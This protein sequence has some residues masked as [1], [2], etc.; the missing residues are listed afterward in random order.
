M[1]PAYGDSEA[2]D[3]GETSD[4]DLSSIQGGVITIGNF[5][6]VH[7]G[8]AALLGHV[9]KLA[10]QLGGPAI[11]MVLDPHPATILRPDVAPKRLTQ[12]ET[13]AELMDQLGIDALVVCKTSRRF[14]DLSAEQFFSSLVQ[15]RLQ[16][17]AMIEGPNFFLVE[18]VAGILRCW[19]SCA[20]RQK[21]NCKS[22]IRCI[23]ALK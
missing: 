17:K 1:Q 15:E 14:L 23:L 21:S 10:D 9:R 5:D 22:W 6:G 11:A 16:S 20:D 2:A 19:L 12:I 8:H 13:R 7:R 3:S 4:G 18:I